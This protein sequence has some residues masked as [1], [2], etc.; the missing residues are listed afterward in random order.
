MVPSEIIALFYWNNHRNNWGADAAKQEWTAMKEWVAK[1]R[2]IAIQS[3]AKA[4]TWPNPNQID[5]RRIHGQPRKPLSFINNLFWAF[6]NVNRNPQ[7]GPR[8][9]S[10]GSGW[11]NLK[12]NVCACQSASSRET[13][14][15]ANELPS[16]TPQHLCRC[17]LSKCPSHTQ[18]NSHF[19]KIMSD[20]TTSRFGFVEFAE[21]WNGRLAMMGFVIGLGTELL[22][23]QGILNQIGLWIST[24]KGAILHANQYLPTPIRFSALPPSPT[25]QSLKTFFSQSKRTMLCLSVDKIQTKSKILIHRSLLA[26]FKMVNQ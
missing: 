12:S 5:D 4:D 15:N 19:H 24:N 10:D 25:E 23:G 8:C 1:C 26:T 20:Q 7:L 11:V 13:W 18:S 2:G 9:Q 21:T 22:T 16:S 14:S 6:Q 17:W 3:K